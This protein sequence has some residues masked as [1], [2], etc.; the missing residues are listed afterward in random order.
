[1]RKKIFI[2]HGTGIKD[3]IGRESGGD[4]DTI[5]S[6]VFYSVWARNFL[7]E[8]LKRE[9]VQGTDYDFD[10]LNYSE[11]LF[12]LNSHRGCDVYIPDFPIDA[13]APRLKLTEIRDDS[14]VDI[15]NKFTEDLGDFRTWIVSKAPLLEKVYKKKFNEIFS[16]TSKITGHQ[17][18]PALKIAHGILKLT[19]M[20]TEISLSVK[21]PALSGVLS[22][23]S[24]EELYS[25]K[26]EILPLL[27]NNI[28]YDMS[29]IVEKKEDILA[30]DAA[31]S[32]DMVTRGR[33]SYTGEFM[34]AAVETA[35]YIAR[36]FEELRKLPFDD[37]HRQRL[38]KVLNILT[39]KLKSLFLKIGSQLQGLEN[40]ARAEEAIRQLVSITDGIESHRPVKKDDGGFRIN[41]MLTAESSGRAVQGIEI[42]FKRLKGA[43]RIFDLKGN[44]IGQQSAVVKTDAAGAAGILYKPS[45]LDEDFRF[46][47]TYNGLH[48]LFTPDAVNAAKDNISPDP[49][50]AQA[51]TLQLLEKMFASLKEN[52]VNVVSIDDHHPYTEEVYNLLK[53]LQSEGVIGSVH[54][55]AKPRG[56]SEKDEEKKC[57][58]DLIYEERVQGKPWDNEGLRYLKKM[59]H[60]QDL[61]LGYIPLGIELSK[62]IGSSFGKIE[63]V[64]KLSEIKSRAELKDIMRTTGWDRKVKEYEN[65]LA[66]VLPRTE[67]NMVYIDFMR[68]P[69]NGKYG[70][71]L[72]FI[73]NLRKNFLLLKEPDKKEIFFRN[74]YCKNPANHLQIVAVLPPFTN[75][76]KGETRINVASALNYLL[77]DKKYYADYF[78]Y[79]YGSGILTT[80]KPNDKE[81]TLDLSELMQSIGTPADGGHSGAATCQPASNPFFPQKRLLKVNERNFIEFLYYIG[82]KIEEYAGGKIELLSVKPVPGKK[83]NEAY[84]K[85]LEKIKNNLIEYVFKKEDSGEEMRALLAKA[86]R[87]SRGQDER[88]PGT[89]QVI[90]YIGREYNPDYIFLLPG[91]LNSM[92]LYNF[93][94]P[95]K[96]LDLTG[97]ARI[98]G[99]DE[100]GGHR[101]FSIATPKRNRRIPRR[102]RKWD[103][104]FLE[105]ARLFSDFINEGR[106][107]WRITEIKQILR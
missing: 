4:L 57:G 38:L 66:K 41:A 20:L 59:A 104:D 89:T 5:S 60:V 107:A 58:A 68:K 105:L 94:D 35:A 54:V 71:H 15:I 70:S 13:I 65:G 93:N 21:S 12:H 1:M 92:L 9:P 72:L 28:K 55:H 24:G 95:E 23:V 10:F 78:F 6:N 53:K 62:L 100:D 81:T 49:A 97:M 51:V 29:E 11:G 91:G 103:S 74:L 19:R 86:P 63:M 3:G 39:G 14:A 7:R 87:V 37:W 77:R 40:A 99:W 67:T 2:I 101:M 73:D 17:E 56:I 30:L 85:V 83:Y 47:L 90:E 76:K 82:G 50:R 25:A 32:R 75:P 61:H 64:K 80:R 26:K 43:G 22:C 96:R 33:V 88:K 8:K 98:I 102:F 52:D 44:E 36:G 42:V 27:G 16:Q 31:H 84:G 69:E 106:N 34:I 45:T 48:F 46:A 79:C 18:V